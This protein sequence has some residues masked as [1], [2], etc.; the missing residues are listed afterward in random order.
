MECSHSVDAR[1]LRSGPHARAVDERV[2]APRAK[3]VRRA[4]DRHQRSIKATRAR[5][6]SHPGWRSRRE[7]CSQRADVRSLV[8]L[9]LVIVQAAPG[10]ASPDRELRMCVDPSSAP[11]THSKLPGFENAMAAVIGRAL[12]ARVEDTWR[13]QRRGFLRDTMLSGDCDMVLAAPYDTARVHTTQRRDRSVEASAVHQLYQLYAHAL[14]DHRAG[15]RHDR[16]ATIARAGRGLRQ[17]GTL[18]VPIWHDT[19]A[20]PRASARRR[21]LL[22]LPPCRRSSLSCA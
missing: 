1:T 8:A 11:F 19:D 10:V 3:T 21:F 14:A 17:P 2:R 20:T 16:G 22:R 18:S 12:E 13:A 7:R 5:T 4:R 15:R 6:A 9:S